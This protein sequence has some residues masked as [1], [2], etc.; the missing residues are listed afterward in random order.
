MTELFENRRVMMG[1]KRV[2]RKVRYHFRSNTHIEL[3]SEKEMAIKS[4]PY[5][6]KLAIQDTCVKDDNIIHIDN[7]QIK[8]AARECVIKELV[9]SGEY[10]TDRVLVIMNPYGY[11]PMSAMAIFRT[12]RPCKTRMWVQCD[13]KSRIIGELPASCDHRVPII[14]CFAGAKNNIYIQLIY[15]GGFRKTLKFSL[16]MEPLPDEMKGMVKVI[17]SKSAAADI[18]CG[19]HV[20]LAVGAA[21]GNGDRCIHSQ[22]AVNIP[23]EIIK[24]NGNRS[25]DGKRRIRGDII[26]EL[27][28]IA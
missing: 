4:Q 1:I 15:F 7:M 8:T 23:S 22:T 14:G 6:N 20:E 28:S 10:T 16:E 26:Y 25:A 21:V 18:N 12:K 27:D 17:E 9:S 19:I 3:M 13:K 11:V 2:L 24:I 5:S